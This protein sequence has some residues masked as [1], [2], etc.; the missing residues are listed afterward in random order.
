M[1]F[2]KSSDANNAVFLKIPKLMLK[3]LFFKRKS[4]PLYQGRVVECL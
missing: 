1:Y 4:L 2:V 3:K